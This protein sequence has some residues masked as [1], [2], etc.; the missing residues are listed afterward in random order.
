MR[1]TH[2]REYESY[3]NQTMVFEEFTA[4]IFDEDRNGAA[5]KGLLDPTPARKLRQNSR[6]DYE[7]TAE[8]YSAVLEW[9]FEAFTL[10][11]LT[12]YQH[13]D[14]LINRDN[15]ATTWRYCRRLRSCPV[16]TT[17]KPTSKQRL[18]NQSNFWRTAVWQVGLGCRYLST[19]KWRSTFLNCSTLTSM[20]LLILHR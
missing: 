15:V 7:L 9:D 12:S 16:N 3:T 8:L 18:R 19:P 20:V 5:Q 4:Q 17:L 6:A 14:V 1:V 11:S 13:D 10:K 2:L